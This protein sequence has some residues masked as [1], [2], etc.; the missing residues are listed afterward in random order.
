[1]SY[2]ITTTEV[3]LAKPGGE[4]LLDVLFPKNAAKSEGAE[5]RKDDRLLGFEKDKARFAA[6]VTQCQDAT[7][8]TE[9]RLRGV[10]AYL[11]PSN[12]GVVEKLNPR[13]VRQKLK[14]KVDDALKVCEL[15]T[16]DGAKKAAAALF[17][18]IEAEFKNEIVR[19]TQR[20]HVE[21]L[22]QKGLA[23][24][25]LLATLQAV[26]AQLDMHLAPFD[27]S[28]IPIAT[29]G[30]T[31]VEIVVQA[32]PLKVAGLQSNP[33]SDSKAG[34]LTLSYG[35]ATTLARTKLEVR[36][37]SYVRVAVGLGF[38]SLRN[39]TV[40]EQRD[41][42]GQVVLRTGQDTG[43][44][45]MILLSHYWYGVDER[46]TQPWSSPWDSTR[47]KTSLVNLIPSIAIGLPLTQQNTLQNFFVGLLFQPIPAV[48]LVFGGHVGRINQLRPEFSDGMTLPIKETGF[49]IDADTLEPVTKMG[50]FLG[51]MVTDSVFAKLI[52]DSLS[53]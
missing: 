4:S 29:R 35:A 24:V 37:L 45:G 18:Q 34:A 21:T 49:R 17:T 6:Q 12:A 40:S 51:V 5:V 27:R 52:R 16:S 19:K 30:N 42:Q 14:D 15:F 10:L 50:W 43:I 44:A 7:L 46:E 47:S 41:A 8:S 20:S 1:M 13:A 28:V 3:P 31:E 25:G 9:Q 2:S 23:Q 53:K 39:D 33:S 26:E 36:S 48:G 22:L 38:T 11:S 32:K